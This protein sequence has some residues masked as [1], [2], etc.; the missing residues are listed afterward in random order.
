MNDNN[1]EFVTLQRCNI[2]KQV[3]RSRGE[4]LAHHYKVHTKLG[5]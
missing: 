1:S 2:C 3:F 4:A 5:Q